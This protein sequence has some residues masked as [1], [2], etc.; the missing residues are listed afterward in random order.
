MHQLL[1][2]VT[3]FH[4]GGARFGITV[5]FSRKLFVAKNDI[6]R[7]FSRNRLQNWGAVRVRIR[8]LGRVRD[9]N[10][11]KI[12]YII[13][14]YLLLAECKVCTASYGPSFSFLF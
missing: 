10:W 13:N 5:V 9:R 1:Y 4:A 3:E 6:E 2:I 7:P 11:D 14:I 12:A 8:F